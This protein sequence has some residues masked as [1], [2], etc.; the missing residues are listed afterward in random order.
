MALG[1]LAAGWLREP[2]GGTNF[3][4]NV[5]Y[6]VVLGMLVSYL[7]APLLYR[8]L[9][10]VGAGLIGRFTRLPPQV[11]VAGT[12]GLIVALTLSILVTAVLSDVPGF[13][14]FWS[15]GI[16]MVLSGAALAF[17]VRNRD[18]M[19]PTRSAAPSVFR[20]LGPIQAPKVVDTS[21]IIDGR[22]PSLVATGFLDGPLIVPDFVVDEL[23][24]L[25]DHSGDGQKRARGR[26]GLEVL[27][28]ITKEG[29]VRVIITERESAST[30]TSTDSRLVEIARQSGARLL[31][32]DFALSKVAGAHGVTV[33]NINDLANALKSIF[34]PGEQISINVIREGREPGQGVAYLPDGTMVVVEGG[35][36]Q[37]G[38]TVQ[39]EV[40]S[41]LQTAVGRMIF[42][43]L[44]PAASARHAGNR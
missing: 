11:V 9:S 10:P 38:R 17:F 8:V 16:T 35:A 12:A 32:T 18:F 36:D 20:S 1:A 23:Q 13:E 31:T 42:A 33:L 44:A 29:L 6:L 7:S 24:R 39:A 5:I 27:E 19:F 21:V 25:A 3:V 43:R 30:P 40:T 14:W 26:R 28:R 22:I 15:V 2:L 4:L 37:V 34:L 41:N